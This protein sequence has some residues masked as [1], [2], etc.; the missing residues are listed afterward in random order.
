VE[1][2]DGNKRYSEWPNYLSDTLVQFD[3]DPA[4]SAGF[5]ASSHFFLSGFRLAKRNS[6]WILL[7]WL[8]SFTTLEVFT[9]DMATRHI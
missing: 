5:C 4:H 2:K 9:K 3:R 7:R 1:I 6:S 8:G